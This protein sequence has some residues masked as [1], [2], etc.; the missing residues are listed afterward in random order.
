MGVPVFRY[1]LAV[2]TISS[3]IAGL[4]G[5]LYVHQNNFASP[6]TFSFF[7]SVL[8][9][10]MAAIGG[11]GRYW[12]GFWGALIFTVMPELM[13]DLQDAELLVFGIAMIVV[14]GFIPGGVAGWL[15]RLRARWGARA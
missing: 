7:T 2:F 11:F 4:A 13:R 10:V 3:A 8:L 6:E 9:L 14:V 15:Q 12:G 5:A 1:K